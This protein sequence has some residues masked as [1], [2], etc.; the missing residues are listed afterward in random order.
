MITVNRFGFDYS[1]T[2]WFLVLKSFYKV[3]PSS[4]AADTTP[5]NRSAFRDYQIQA[6]CSWTAKVTHPL[7]SHLF[8]HKNASESTFGHFLGS[9]YSEVSIQTVIPD[10]K[11]L[12]V[13]YLFERVFF[14][15][16][17]GAIC[18]PLNVVLEN[19]GQSLKLGD[20]KPGNHQVC[21][22]YF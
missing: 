1:G 13:I 20:I 14:L 8:T 22:I 12:S 3:L 10:M 15:S 16:N 17:R 9:V 7:R 2:L 5:L 18:G 11:F 19:N 6:Y 21:L 4:Q